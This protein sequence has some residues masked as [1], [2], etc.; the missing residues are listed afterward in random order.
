MET[1]IILRVLG[2]DVDDRQTMELI[3]EHLDDLA[4]S[5]VDGV[6]R[7]TLFTQEVDT[8]SQ[9]VDIAHRIEN[10]LSGARVDEADEELVTIPDISA[11]TKMHRETVRSWINGTRGPGDFPLPSA[12]FGGGER[13]SM[14]AWRWADVN[15][16]LDRHYALGDGYS[17]PTKKEYAE[18]NAFLARADYMLAVALS[19]APQPPVNVTQ[20]QYLKPQ[21]APFL[22]LGAAAA[23][24]SMT[25]SSNLLIE[26]EK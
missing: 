24:W 23:L 20:V 14:K 17:Y 25:A 19:A 6:T 5:I 11:R 3:A 1:R 21:E 9:A 8:V 12:S 15:R 26:A 7:V 13:G 10:K 22:A 16:W 18:I 2:V 4:W